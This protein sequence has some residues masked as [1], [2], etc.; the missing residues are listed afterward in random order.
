MSFP[1]NT[2][3]I[4]AD[5]V[6]APAY[7]ILCFSL[8]LTLMY[9]IVAKNTR[10]VQVY[11]GLY[12]TC[13]RIKFSQSSIINDFLKN[14]CTMNINKFMLKK[15]Q[16]RCDT[17]ERT[18]AFEFSKGSQR[19]CAPVLLFIID[20]TSICITLQLSISVQSDDYRPTGSSQDYRI[21]AQLLEASSVS[22]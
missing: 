20:I 8:R 16:V 3:D 21:S 7:R 22:C 9:Y 10:L 5:R 12:C 13:F 19:P 11:I 2:V 6:Y 15:I 18:T 14:S 4:L 1:A 17:H